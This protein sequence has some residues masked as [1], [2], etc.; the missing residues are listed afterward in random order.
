MMRALA[1][2]AAPTRAVSRVR[3][4]YFVQA[5]TLGLIKI[6]VTND[7]A[8]RLGSLQTFSP[9]RLKLLGLMICP[10][11][12]SL[13]AWLHNRFADARSHGEWF[14]PTPAL[15]EFIAAYALNEEDAMIAK[16]QESGRVGRPSHGLPWVLPLPIQSGDER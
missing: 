2:K 16:I 7:T 6:G 11:R 9:D 10:A 13:E 5:E 8:R 15:V 12:G 1:Q 4:V 14:N 3:E